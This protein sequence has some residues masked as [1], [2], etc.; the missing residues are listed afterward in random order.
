[1]KK[2]K[3]LLLDIG[4]S[5]IKAALL[6]KSR[7]GRVSRFS[8]EDFA[9]GLAGLI[10]KTTVTECLAV[11]VNPVYERWMKK[12]N[13]F[14]KT[15]IIFAGRDLPVLIRSQYSKELGIDRKVNIYS[16]SALYKNT[17]IVISL[18]TALTFDFLSK[19]GLHLG[20]MIFPGTNTAVSSLLNK[21]SL[22][23]ENLLLR[24]PYA[25]IA[26][27]TRQ[28]VCSGAYWGYSLL[29]KAVVEEFKSKHNPNC[30]V[31]AAGGGINN[32]NAKIADIDIIDRKLT[33]KG[34]T[35][36]LNHYRR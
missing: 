28:A 17:G 10:K 16:A 23:P 32:I 14:K 25:F 22:L 21:A 29:I 11:S 4:N 3:T 20:G 31:V 30:K 27:N 26:K 5:F 9:L 7:I 36:L 33:F 19:K 2:N 35:L 1:M 12:S 8:E 6:T 24:R 13:L 15:K 34:L 18:G